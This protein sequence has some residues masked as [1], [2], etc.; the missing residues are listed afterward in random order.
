MFFPSTFFTYR[1]CVFEEIAERAI[2][3]WLRQ[4]SRLASS[5]AGGHFSNNGKTE[6]FCKQANLYDTLIES[7]WNLEKLE[8]NEIVCS[9]NFD[10]Y[11]NAR[12]AFE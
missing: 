5:L 12:P 11:S 4:F 3:K 2:F 6:D 1:S 9:L 10:I 8:T 7:A